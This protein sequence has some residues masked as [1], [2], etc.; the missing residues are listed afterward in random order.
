M[1]NKYLKITLVFFFVFLFPRVLYQGYMV[2]IVENCD[3]K[4]GCFGTFQLSLFIASV[5]GLISALSYAAVISL[6]KRLEFSWQAVASSLFLGS[7]YN[8]A[9]LK[10]E[11]LHSELSMAITWACISFFVCLGTVL[12]PKNI[13][14]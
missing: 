9:I 5:F 1:I 6:L 7:I 10:S 13:T 3:P 4:F 14:S 8:Q 11:Y 12:W 2:F